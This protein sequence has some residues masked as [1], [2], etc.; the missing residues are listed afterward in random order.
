MCL[1][2]WD[3]AFNATALAAP[4][5]L[6]SQQCEVYLLIVVRQQRLFHL[7]KLSH[8]DVFEPSTTWAVS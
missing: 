4:H 8:V 3:V 7:L 6:L 2:A 5:Q 1:G